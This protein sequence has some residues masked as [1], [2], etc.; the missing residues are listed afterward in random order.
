[1]ARIPPSLAVP[2]SS[3]SV[4]PSKIEWMEPPHAI[5]ESFTVDIVASDC[6]NLYTWSVGIKWN[7]AVLDYVSFTWG[8]GFGIL[9]GGSLKI[10]GQVN[11]ATGE[12][13][14]AWSETST[15]N[16]VTNA[17]L[18]LITFTFTVTDY[19]TSNITIMEDPT[20]TLVMDS[21]MVTYFS[22]Q[23]ALNHGS[24][25][26]A[27]FSRF[28]VIWQAKTYYVTVVSSS[29]VTNFSFSQQDKQIS[30]NVN[31]T[32]G[33]TGFCNVTVPKKLMRC[34][35]LADWIVKIDDAPISYIATE[36][37]THTMLYFTYTHSIHQVKIISTYVIVEVTHDLVASIEAPEL[38]EP[39]N[40]AILN[41]T[42]RNQGDATEPSVELRLLIN[43]SLIESTVF[44]PLSVNSSFTLS[45]SWTPTVEGI[46]NV[47]AYAPPLVGENLT[48]DNIASAYVKAISGTPAANFTI[49]PDPPYFAPATLTFDASSSNPNGGSIVSY[50]WD[51]G[52]ENVTTVDVPVIVH[53]YTETG[54]FT[55]TLNVT[56]S[57]GLWD[58][59]SKSVTVKKPPTAS[60]TFSPTTPLVGEAVTF[61]ASASTPDG[62]TIASYTWDFGDGNVTTVTTPII[63]HVY[64]LYGTF[65]VTLNVTD[66][67]GL[68]DTETKSITVKKTPVASF[69]FTPASPL[70]G[71]AITFDASASTPDGGNIVS[72]SW[73][74][75]DENVTTVEDPII[76]HIYATFGNYSV[77]LNVTD[78]EGLW[79]TKTKTVHVMIHPVASFTYSPLVPVA[80]R[81]TTFN[82]SASYDLDGWITSYWFD[83]GDGT[84]IRVNGP[85][86]TFVTHTYTA[87]GN[88]TVNFSVTDNDGLTD[89]ATESFE[90]VE[91]ITDAGVV[92][93]AVSTTKAYTITWRY[94]VN[95]NV[96]VKNKGTNTE[97]FN[98]IAYYDG[99]AIG[100]EAVTLAPE[101]STTLTFGWNV[102]VVP[103]GYYTISAETEVLPFEANTTDNTLTDGTVRIMFPGDASGNNFVDGVDFG[104]LGK[105][106]FTQDPRADFNGDGFVNA[107]DFAILG[108]YWFQ[109]P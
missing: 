43:G 63:V 20:F 8:T 65:T 83:F 27:T 82:C 52:D 46:Y 56:D 2:V 45:R 69:I 99:N 109:G 102:T 76:V 108:R 78:S 98:T 12:T 60:F 96:T 42:V 53:V 79:G 9:S 100:T 19:G 47:T 41:A 101:E 92:N 75:G 97:T 35:S 87:V 23:F 37:A 50:T 71:E 94:L 4:V 33:T 68:W 77:T 107:I 22:P 16:P 89:F 80:N 25:M 59:Q 57:E 5:G 84:S 81:T 86:L 64:T 67:E 38:L 70:M 88:Y 85:G 40:S 51:F 32:D 105:Y 1:M 93:V 73:D 14:S 91:R 72:Y 44:G 18:K 17:S 62:G 95:I 31:G 29:V 49:S 55:V 36:N 6:V 34:D 54:T 13:T 24:F 58:T 11:H 48:A 90:V 21:D 104:I 3:F 39:G 15:A 30:F 26:F 106:W 28:S 61:D 74:F 66:T 103:C 7:P 10:A